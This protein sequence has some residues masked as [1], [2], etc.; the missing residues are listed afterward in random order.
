MA[1]RVRPRAT[2]EMHGVGSFFDPR[3]DDASKFPIAAKNG[4]GHLQINADD[5][6]AP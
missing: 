1:V 3:L 4:F 6:Q 2:D 5:D